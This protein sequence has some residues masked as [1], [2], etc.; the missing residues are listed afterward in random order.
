MRE[1]QEADVGVTGTCAE[2]FYLTLP[3]DIEIDSERPVAPGALGRVF[4][5]A[6]IELPADQQLDADVDDDL[7]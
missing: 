7:F 3:E 4:S 2:I 5:A 1:Q 6:F